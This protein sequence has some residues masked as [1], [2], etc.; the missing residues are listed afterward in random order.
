MT[1]IVCVVM[2]VLMFF[3]GVAQ[4]DKLAIVDVERIFR[5]SEPGKAGEAHLKQARDI[6]QKGLDEARALYKGQEDTPKARAELRN[7]QA[8]LER[9]LAADR[10]AVRQVLTTTLEKVVRAWFDGPGQ[11]AATR[12]VAPASAF[13]AYSP[14]LDV[15]DAILREMNKEKPAF[16]ALP[17][18]TVKANPSAQ[19]APPAKPAPASPA[20]PARQPARPRTP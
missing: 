9:Q 6:L 4:A 13:F 16:H 15:T 2:F 1:R 19:A 17:T 8:A 14:T 18:V 20:A 5:E 7:A 11:R 12:A 3:C 10:L